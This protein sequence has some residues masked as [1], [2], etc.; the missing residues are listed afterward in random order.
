MKSSPETKETWQLNEMY[1]LRINSSSKENQTNQTN[2]TKK[3]QAIKEITG[4]IWIWTTRYYN[5]KFL[6]LYNDTV[7]IQNTVLGLRDSTV[8]YL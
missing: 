8:N 7:V 2:Q 3:T 5:I 1:G 4:P 6:K